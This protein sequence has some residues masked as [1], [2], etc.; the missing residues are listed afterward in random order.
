MFLLYWQRDVLPQIH[1]NNLY[2][3]LQTDLGQPQSYLLSDWL[4]HD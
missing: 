2:D 4:L 3:M 1:V